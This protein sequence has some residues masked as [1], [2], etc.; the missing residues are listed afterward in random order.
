MPTTVDP[1]SAPG[2]LRR[3]TDAASRTVARSV[4]GVRCVAANGS[5]AQ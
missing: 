2:Q 5:Q 1:A 4:R 3:S